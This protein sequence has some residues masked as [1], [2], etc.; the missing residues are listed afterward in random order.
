M[1]K[2]YNFP[3]L[4]LL[5]LGITILGMLATVVTLVLAMLDKLPFKLLLYTVALMMGGFILMLLEY[6]VENHRFDTA[7]RRVSARRSIELRQ[8]KERVGKDEL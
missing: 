5:G 3:K 7:I 1:P 2:R 4:F 6:V 8:L